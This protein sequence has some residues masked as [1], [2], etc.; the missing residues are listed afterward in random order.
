MDSTDFEY[1][2]RTQQAKLL[3]LTNSK[4]D[5]LLQYVSNEY[6]IISRLLNSP[7]SPLSEETYKTLLETTPE[8][9]SSKTDFKLL[10]ET[11]TYY[12][13]Y[14]VYQYLN[15]LSTLTKKSISDIWTSNELLL[16]GNLI[17][18]FPFGILLLHNLKFLTITYTNISSLPFEIGSLTKLE[19]LI[20]FN[21][22]LEDLP[23]SIG[24][25]SNLTVLNLSNNI[26][27]HLPATIGNL[28]RL[29]EL[30]LDGNQLIDIPIQI[31][32]L[33]QLQTLNLSTNR[34]SVIPQ[35]IS[36]LPN[37]QELDISVN[38]LPE[39]FPYNIFSNTRLIK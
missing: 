7:P 30:Y 24:S 31:V 23:E 5:L 3:L 1:I 28:S 8:F 21:N 38:P 37:L 29:S 36:T 25:L 33:R 32:N 22:K 12:D 19:K 34:L 20:L 4:Y 27:K 9:L 2:R 26:L 16:S 13:T 6:D 14:D 18:E 15:K 39:N 17:D 11:D 10:F 35:G